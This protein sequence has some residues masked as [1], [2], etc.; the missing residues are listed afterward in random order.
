MAPRQLFPHDY[1]HRPKARKIRNPGIPV[2]RLWIVE[3]KGLC[4]DSRPRLSIRAK[5]E[6]VSCGAITCFAAGACPERSRRIIPTD[7]WYI[8]PILATNNQPTIVISPHLKKSKYGQYQEAWHL[9]MRQS[10]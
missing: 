5:L 9:L 6:K 10:P 2:S 1:E 4:G 3:R 7:T 8:L